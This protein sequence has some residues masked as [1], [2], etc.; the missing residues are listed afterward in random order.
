MRFVAIFCELLL[1]GAFFLFF[2]VAYVF[3]NCNKLFFFAK[4]YTKCCKVSMRCYK[5]VCFSDFLIMFYQYIAIHDF[6]LLPFA[7][8]IDSG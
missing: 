5:F 6:L 3:L 1:E 8:F 2:D 7:I 4:S